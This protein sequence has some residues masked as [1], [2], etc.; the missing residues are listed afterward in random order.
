MKAETIKLVLA[1][2]KIVEISNDDESEHLLLC[3][4]NASYH[5]EATNPGHMLGPSPLQSAIILFKDKHPAM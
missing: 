2:S 1:H 4:N 5:S 3:L